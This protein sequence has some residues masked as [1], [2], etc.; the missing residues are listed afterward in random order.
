MIL[1]YKLN[2]FLEF[3]VVNYLRKLEKEKRDE[4]FY[5]KILEDIR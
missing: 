2:K 1:L 4:E 5:R 3:I